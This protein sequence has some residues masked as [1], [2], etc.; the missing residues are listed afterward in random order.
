M[1]LP[2]NQLPDRPLKRF[3][4]GFAVLGLVMF[5]GFALYSDSLKEVA[6]EA[7]GVG[8]AF[9]LIGGILAAFGKKW[10]RCVV[11]FAGEIISNP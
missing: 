4:I 8:V 9:G 3:F 2:D 7:A 11:T 6:T 5:I 10:L 1:D